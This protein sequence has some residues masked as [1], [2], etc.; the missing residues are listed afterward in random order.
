MAGVHGI[1][2]ASYQ[3]GGVYNAAP[4][5]RWIRW[6]SVAELVLELPHSVALEFVPYIVIPL[7]YSCSIHSPYAIMSV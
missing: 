2:I 4:Y 7:L 5:L 1:L 6:L 3:V